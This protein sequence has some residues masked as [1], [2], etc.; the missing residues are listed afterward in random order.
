MNEG[1]DS[2]ELGLGPECVC[3]CVYSTVQCVGVNDSVGFVIRRSSS[4]LQESLIS[5]A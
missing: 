4:L 2:V 1:T 5:R 3:V